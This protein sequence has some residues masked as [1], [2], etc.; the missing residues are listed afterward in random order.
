MADNYLENKM[1]EH[2]A[3]RRT[4]RRTVAGPVKFNPLRVLVAGCMLDIAE[5]V[6]ESFIA[7]GCRVACLSDIQVA[8]ARCFSSQTGCREAIGRLMHDWHEIDLLILTGDAPGVA[9]ALAEA[10]RAL[11]PAL[12]AK[13]PRAIS[14]D[15]PCP[16]SLQ[17]DTQAG[18][19]P[20]SV[21]RLCVLLA[22]PDAA[23]LFDRTAI[24]R[25]R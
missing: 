2:M 14:V 10:R 21:S 6:A 24:L 8:G 15:S 9:D 23:P 18:A 17:L 3:G 16:G 20:Q 22:A 19:T 4:V 7:A 25:Y 12:R 1:A 11:P 5:A 13:T